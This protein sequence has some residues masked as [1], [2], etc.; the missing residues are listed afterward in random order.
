MRTRIDVVGLILGAVFLAYSLTPSLLPRP[1][2]MQGVLSGLSFAAGYALGTGALALWRYLQLPALTARQARALRGLGYAVCG[3]LVAA[4][5][6]R[7]AGW[8]KEIHGL[9]G[10]EEPAGTSLFLLLLV[11]ALTFSV[12]LGLARLFRWSS[13]T[14][15]R[16]LARHAPPRLASVLAVAVSVVLF[17]TAIDGVLFRFLLHTADRSFQQLDA[18]IDDDLPRPAHWDQ[19]GSTASL[20]DWEDLGRQGRNFVSGGPDAAQL[21]AFFGAPRPRPL[22]VYVGLNSA[23]TA[24]ERARLALDE[25]IRVGGFERSVLLLVTPTGTGWID[26]AGQDTA[27]YLL[28]GDVATVSAQYSYLS[29]PLA[30][31][32]EGDY[33]VEMARALFQAI[34]GHWRSLPAAQRPRL[35]L[36]G[37]S[38]GSLNSDLSFDFYDIID[39]PFDGALWVGPP[40]RH[41]TWRAVTAERQPDSPIWLPRF[42]DGSVVRFMNQ[43]G[44]LAEATEEWGAF[45]I[46]LL[47]YGS[48]P[49]TFFSPR[50][51]WRKPEWLHGPRAPDVSAEFRWFPVVTMLQLAADMLVGTAPKGFGHEYA[52][53]HYLDAW[54]A[55]MQP[56]GWSEEELERLRALFER[57]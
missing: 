39:A 53:T 51:A 5:L 47:Q 49:I 52:A 6:W 12:A 15:S 24:A 55:L 33:G 16:R 21:S 45:R 32:T 18:L 11:A 43:R 50:S 40:F 34:Y 10:M 27:E 29:S 38:L 1:P 44:G 57:H 28:Y 48:D 26:P 46:A 17:W 42:R 56:E 19:A 23:G 22:R 8:Q 3:L 4:S 30:L 37:L 25:L 36:Q 2:L 31:L 54:M 14:L 13:R 35:Y 7:A 20:L 41:D 9:M